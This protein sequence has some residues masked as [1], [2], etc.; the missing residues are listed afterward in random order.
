MNLYVYLMGGLGNQMFQYAAGIS[1]LTEYPEFTNLKIDASFYNNQQRK[2]IVDGMT[3]RG[4]DL[5]LFNIKY[6]QVEETPEG[7]VMLQGWFQNIKEFDNVIDDIRQQFTFKNTFPENIQTLSEKIKDTE[8]SVCIHVR[9][10]DYVNNPTANAHHGVL[11]L[12]Y[13]ES[14]KKIIENRYKNPVYYVFS[15]D[16]EWCKNNLTSDC[17]INFIGNDYS[18]D[19][20]SGHL[21][22]MQMCKNHIIANSSFSWWGAFLSESKYTISP[23]KWRKDGTGYDIILDNWVKL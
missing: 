1:A 14:A 12:E 11:E 16:I 7:A 23:K 17:E 5:D 4:Y 6:D 21:H 10:S 15:D 13:Y 9:R 19:R 3:G 2:V 20:D 22:L 8:D 18:G